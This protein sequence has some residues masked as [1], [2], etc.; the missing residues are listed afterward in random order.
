M[1]QGEFKKSPRS[2]IIGK[3]LA[4]T[5]MRAGN[6][7]VAI[8]AYERMLQT[9]PKEPGLYYSLAQEYFAKQDYEHAAQALKQA[10]QLAPQDGRIDMMLAAALNQLGRNGDA[11]PT[12]SGFC[13]VSPTILWR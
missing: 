12:W 6:Y 1:L 11:R 4:F 13:K 7:G 3:L 10:Q 8:E 9:S 5:A 2:P